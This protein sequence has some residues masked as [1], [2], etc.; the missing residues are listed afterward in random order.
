MRFSSITNFINEFQANPVG[1]LITL[2]YLA[3]VILFSLIIH[4]CAHGYVALKCGD[5]TAKM[6]GR[7]TLDPRKH[8]D[9][10]G[11]ICM[12]FLRFGWAKP[13]PVNPRNFRNYRKDYILVSLAGIVTNLLICMISLMISALMVR[14]IWCKE[15]IDYLADA[16][17]KNVLIDIYGSTSI[18]LKDISVYYS[19]MSKLIDLLQEYSGY[20]GFEF[21]SYAIY[22]GQFDIY[23]VLTSG[24]G[25]M[26]VQRLFLMLAQMNLALAVFNLLPV[27]PLDGFRFMDQFV[28]KGQLRMTPQTM[29]YIRIGFLVVCMSGLL[30]GLL[31]TVN[32][33]VFGWLCKLFAMLI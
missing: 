20:S 30:T 10:I 22:S 19:D 13:V 28:F 33:A 29:Q 31:T 16:G 6:M 7:L 27:P 11:T 21:S 3:V 26:Y 14:A 4:E 15:L 2:A 1:S 12:I 8:L 9:P 32:S 5:P 18:Y 24:T 25:L 17:Q 23:R